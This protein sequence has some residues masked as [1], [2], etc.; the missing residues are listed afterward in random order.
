M[1]KFYKKNLF[2]APASYFIE[3]LEGQERENFENGVFQYD[4]M[5][6]GMVEEIN[7]KNERFLVSFKAP[8]DNYAEPE[9]T[10]SIDCYGADLSKFHVVESVERIDFYQFLKIKERDIIDIIKKEQRY[11]KEE[12]LQ[13]GAYGS[14]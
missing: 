8:D 3:N 11:G 1:E 4:G 5:V 6:C 2:V 9:I 13:Q 12:G 10:L 14:L 7:F